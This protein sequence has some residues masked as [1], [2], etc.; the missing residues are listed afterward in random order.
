MRFTFT[1]LLALL[2]S[3]RAYSAMDIGVSPLFIY[4][5]WDQVRAYKN[6][7]PSSDGM[8]LDLD[9]NSDGYMI[10]TKRRIGAMSGFVSSSWQT[11]LNADLGMTLKK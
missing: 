6:L 4:G 8:T 11:V 3:F 9:Q 10:Q 7:S 5:E 2:S 1:L